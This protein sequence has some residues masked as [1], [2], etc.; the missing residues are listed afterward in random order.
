MV[1]IYLIDHVVCTGL[2]LIEHQVALTA[3]LQLHVIETDP[4]FITTITTIGNINTDGQ[5][6]LSI[7]CGSLDIDQEVIVIQ[8]GLESLTRLGVFGIKELACIIRLFLFVDGGQICCKHVEVSAHG[9]IISRVSRTGSIEFGGHTAARCLRHET[10]AAHT[11][12]SLTIDFH[13]LA[14]CTLT[15]I[16]DIGSPVLSIEVIV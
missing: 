12:P 13:L 5:R 8:I 10:L 2:I 14:D 9:L 6:L 4:I 11:I 15:T 3:V 7:I 16:D 1:G